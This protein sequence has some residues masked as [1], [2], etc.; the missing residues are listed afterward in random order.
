MTDAQAETTVPDRLVSE[1]QRLSPVS[2]IYFVLKFIIGFAKQGFQNI[3]IFGG[4]FFFSGGDN[5]L[6]VVALVAL[7]AL[8]F[9]IVASVLS[10]LNFRFRVNKN[11]FLIHKGVL[12][13]KRLT[14]S[15]DRIQNIA[16]KEPLYFRPFGLVNMALESAG[17]ATEEVSL[18][19]IDRR[20]AE[21]LRGSVLSTP[22]D[23][24]VH[25]RTPAP[26]AV[27]AP[28]PDDST[29][30]LLHHPV[31]EL[32]R[33]GLSNNNVW[34]F[35]GLAAG[36]ISQIDEKLGD[37][38]RGWL[39][40][41]ESFISSHST[42]LVAALFAGIVLFILAL[43]LLGSVIGAIVIYYDYRLSFS[44]NRFHR[45]KGLFERSETSL[46]SGKV[47]ALKISQPWPARLL[48]RSHI[49]LL[50]VGFSTAYDQ[51][52]G[53]TRQAKF[54]VPSMTDDQIDRLAE[55][56]YPDLNRKQVNFTAVDRL[57]LKRLFWLTFMT[58]A[59]LVAALLA[60]L[61]GT[62]WFLLLTLVPVA[63]YPLMRLRYNRHGYWSDGRYI[64]VRHGLLGH[65]IVIFPVHKAQAV[66][67]KRSP[68]QRRKGLATL[69]VKL[70]GQTIKL[71]YIP[72]RAA[73]GLRDHIL[74]VLATDHT[75]WM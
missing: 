40:V 59:A 64:A 74:R 34:V 38:L 15:F 28:T 42:A 51:P 47:Q 55:K 46:P 71:P 73:T 21:D 7:G 69:V 70:A 26:E 50:Q 10:Y 52:G 3:A 66:S 36:A 62:P 19:G 1:W 6:M 18:A 32:V 75:P 68:G 13:K 72:H 61:A 4:I 5:R 29:A 57:Y 54:I 23:T 9:L 12:Q 45:L 20:L 53:A 56:L 35:A 37:Q 43:L 16:L 2:I 67:V 48:A 65:T 63:L 27:A 25:P 14:L 11:A 39:S 41:P 58:P 30:P 22:C 8:V 17:S 49:T 31:A 24:V 60:G 44:D 33:Y